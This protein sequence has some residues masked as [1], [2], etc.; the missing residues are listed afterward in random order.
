MSTKMKIWLTIRTV[1]ATIA[2]SKIERELERL[3]RKL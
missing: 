2:S 3:R 1:H